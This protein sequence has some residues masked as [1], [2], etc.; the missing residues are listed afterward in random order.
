MKRFA[1]V[2]LALV[3]LLLA[4]PAAFA[5][6]RANGCVVD[7]YGNAWTHGGT[8]EC[9]QKTTNIVVGSG[10]IGADGCY[11][12]FIGNGLEVTCTIDPAAGPLGDPAPYTCVV[13]TDTSYSP[14]PWDCGPGSTGTGPNAVTLSTLGGTSTP[15]LSAGLV[16][17]ALSLVLGGATLVRRPR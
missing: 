4:S 7:G 15:V 16:I 17:L 9:R 13:P 12:V 3:L 1:P 6:D 5:W 14:L 10:S 11:S 8:V 2:L